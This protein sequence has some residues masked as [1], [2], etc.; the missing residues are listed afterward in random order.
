MKN[1]FVPIRS[2][3][4]S[5]SESK[6]STSLLKLGKEPWRCKGCEQLFYNTEYFPPNEKDG[7][8][9]G[10]KVYP[11]PGAPFPKYLMEHGNVCWVCYTLYQIVAGNDYHIKLHEQY[12]NEEFKRTQKNKRL[13]QDGDYFK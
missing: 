2:R 6:D 1:F 8:K 5:V 7:I 4:I 9:E 13:G 3:G 11:V 10:S 12:I